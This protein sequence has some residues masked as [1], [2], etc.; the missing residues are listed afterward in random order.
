MAFILV[1]LIVYTIEAIVHMKDY[2]D[3]LYHF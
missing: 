2:Y 3:Q 1:L